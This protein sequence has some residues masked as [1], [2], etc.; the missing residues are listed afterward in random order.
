MVKTKTLKYTFSFILIAFA[1]ESAAQDPDRKGLSL[2]ADL[3]RLASPLIDSTGFGWEFSGD[4]EFFNDL[5][6]AV[7]IGSQTI[8]LNKAFYDYH[9]SGIYT[10]LGAEYNFG[11]HLDVLPGD[12][13]FIGL[14][15]AFTTFAHSAENIVIEDGNWGNFSGGSVA[16]RWI[17]ANWME[18]SAGMRA[19]LF[20]NFYLGWS[21]RIRIRLGVTDDPVLAP[22]SLPGYGPA[23]NDTGVGI[24][25]SLYYK[26][27]LTISFKKKEKKAEGE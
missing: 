3:S 18:V 14:R 9:S 11:K 10:R 16:N 12:K 6:G 19:H 4:Y 7:E 22:Y 25:Y 15:Y 17:F 21:A 20:H 13:M 26:I 2:G 1:L 8:D 27:P 24:N 23:W 5:F